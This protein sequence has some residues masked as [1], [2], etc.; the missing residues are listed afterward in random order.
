VVIFPPAG[1]KNDLHRAFAHSALACGSMV[2][3]LSCVSFLRPAGRKNDTQE[4]KATD[5]LKSYYKRK[6]HAAAGCSVMM[7]PN[8]ELL[9][10]IQQI[11][12]QQI[13]L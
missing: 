1:R 2:L 11:A 13:I 9:I 8:S 4:L 6:Y 3:Y 12:I 5:K 10:G 7:H